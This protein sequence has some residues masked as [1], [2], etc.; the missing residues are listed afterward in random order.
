[1]KLLCDNP[2]HNKPIEVES[3]TQYVKLR[4]NNCYT[5]LCSEDCRKKHTSCGF[6]TEEW[7][8]LGKY[9]KI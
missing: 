1:M 4:C 8:L 3:Y 2:K 6:S 9:Y 7:K 5:F